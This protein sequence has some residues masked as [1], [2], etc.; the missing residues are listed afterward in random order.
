VYVLSSFFL[1]APRAMSVPL[2]TA[3]IMSHSTWEWSLFW[4]LWDWW[5]SSLPR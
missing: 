1:Q 2:T 3:F 5:P 4:G